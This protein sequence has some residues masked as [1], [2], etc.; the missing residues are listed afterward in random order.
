MTGVSMRWVSHCKLVSWPRESSASASTCRCSARILSRQAQAQV[1]GC[2]HGPT[3]RS[4]P[5]HRPRVTMESSKGPSALRSPLS[6]CSLKNGGR[7][8]EA[9]GDADLCAADAESQSYTSTSIHLL[10]AGNAPRERFR[11]RLGL[12]LR[13]AARQGRRAGGRSCRLGHRAPLE[14]VQ[15]RRER[16]ERRHLAR[17]HSH[18]RTALFQA[19][20]TCN[21]GP[22]WQ[23]RSRQARRRSGRRGR[24]SGY[25]R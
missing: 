13:Q 23:P 4:A 2:K 15:Q 16:R 19:T 25:G 7:S 22:V 5:P 10:S 18:L 17:R 24:R 11:L 8:S 1:Q 12:R 6:I 3:C 14:L 9:T 20:H 21:R